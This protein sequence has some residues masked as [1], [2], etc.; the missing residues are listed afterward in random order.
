[1]LTSLVWP[2]WPTC[3]PVSPRHGQTSATTQQLVSDVDTASV[4]TSVDVT[5]QSRHAPRTASPATFAQDTLALND[6]TGLKRP[7]VLVRMTSWDLSH[8]LSWLRIFGLHYSVIGNVRICL[9]LVARICKCV[10]VVVSVCALVCSVV[11]A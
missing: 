1:M 7:H 2:S 6:V 3:W 4:I 5:P 10:W 9:C 8:H 11:R